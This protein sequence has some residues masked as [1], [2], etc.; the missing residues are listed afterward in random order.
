MLV[1]GVTAPIV[2]YVLGLGGDAGWHGKAKLIMSAG[3][4]V[5]GTFGIAYRPAE[6]AGGGTGG[7]LLW[8]S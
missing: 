3:A 5:S 6:S 8:L 2:P 4:A 7:R 1:V